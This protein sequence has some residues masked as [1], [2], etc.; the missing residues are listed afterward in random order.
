MKK[1]FNH[2]SMKT[3]LYITWII[4]LFGC[5][6]EG[7]L[8]QKI[9]YENFYV[10]EDDP[11]DPVK[12]RVYEIYKKYNVPV[13]FNDTIS[14]SFVQEDVYGNPIYQ[15]ETL[16]LA[17]SF[18][19]YSQQKFQYE[20]LEEPEE[21]LKALD[22]IENY[23][24]LVTK[25]LYP[26]NFFVV[27]SVKMQDRNN[28]ISEIKAGA[29]Q[30]YLRTLLMTGDWRNDGVIRDLP[31]G[32]MREMV[33]SKILNYGTSLALFYSISKPEWYDIYFSD[34]DPNYFEYL[35]YPN[36][37]GFTGSWDYIPGKGAFG[38]LCFDDNWTQARWFTPEGLE[39]FRTCVREKVG[40]WGFVSSGIGTLWTPRNKE[41][42]LVGYIT[43][44]LRWPPEEFKEKWGKSPL[45]MQKYNILY[46]VVINE[47]GVKL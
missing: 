37:F 40:A 38:P 22:I 39:N 14:K 8:T 23:L 44:M 2:R 18:S 41:A 29:F 32:M 27:K 1:L 35:V 10:I 17:W 19:S 24:S 3:I 36:D 30:I 6:K 12:H 31:E 21:Q 25:A 11:S 7:T 42:D 20:Y 9:E 33:K 5:T 15:Y 46:E 34:L 4:F 28:R 13:Y 16:D 45:V 43:E 26:Y 47:L